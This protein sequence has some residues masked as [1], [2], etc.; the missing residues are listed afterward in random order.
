MQPAATM[1]T[2]TSIFADADRQ[3]DMA[4]AE[5]CV[6]R[7][8]IRV[9]DYLEN[10]G[11]VGEGGYGEVFKAKVR[12][13]GQLVAVK[14]LLRNHEKEGFPIT[15]IREVKL[16]RDLDSPNVIQVLNIVTSSETENIFVLFEY[17]EHDLD[18]LMHTVHLQPSHVKCY[19]R[20]LL[21]G[22]QC[23]HSHH[24]M[25]RDLKPSNVLLNNKGGLKICDFGFARHCRSS[26]QDSL[27]TPVVVTMWYRSP[28]VLLGFPDYGT[29]VDMWSAGCILFE[30]CALGK[31]LFSGKDELGQ[32]GRIYDV[33][34]TPNPGNCPQL[35]LFPVYS[36]MKPAQE[37]PRVLAEKCRRNG[38]A[39]DATDLCER[40]LCYD[41]DARAT[42]EQA[43][44]HHY[45][46]THPLPEEP[47]RMPA[48]EDKHKYVFRA[49]K[50]REMAEK[51]Q[52]EKDAA[53]AL[54]AVTLTTAS[55]LPAAA[56][57]PLARARESHQQ[58]VSAVSS[59]SARGRESARRLAAP[60]AAAVAS[61][62]HRKVGSPVTPPK[63]A[64]LSKVP[65]HIK[66]LAQNIL[67]TTKRPPTVGGEPDPK[68]PKY[69]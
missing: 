65:P 46:T 53:Q 10:I 69:D 4:F 41:L 38:L 3:A 13:T 61:Q 36:S 8:P 23:L 62:P 50:K 21:E 66:E 33:C 29:A 49:K 57:D 12:A 37:L 39:P 5:W 32:L 2:T 59:R 35:H 58:H 17:M 47:D 43:L 20:Q 30:M 18:G 56:V 15:S 11:K 48:Y 44:R 51:A 19:M 26:K 45:F 68:K 54:K 7:T 14:K 16:L 52:R 28:E 42:A 63:P 1:N 31:V 55:A 24:I 67:R 64:P 6:G 40:L 9:Q 34:G 60:G 22:L 27:Y 25:H